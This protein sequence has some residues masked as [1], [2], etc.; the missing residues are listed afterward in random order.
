MARRSMRR[1]AALLTIVCAEGL[2][3]Q[4]EGEPLVTADEVFTAVKESCDKFQWIAVLTL[5]NTEDLSLPYISMRRFPYDRGVAAAN[6]TALKAEI[7]YLKAVV[8]GER[9]LITMD[10]FDSYRPAYGGARQTRDIR[11]NLLALLSSLLLAKEFTSEQ[12]P[13]DE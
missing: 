10:F 1:I 9:W 13:A 5:Q 4:A 2:Y 8:N 6:G 3:A 12:K 11:R 7:I